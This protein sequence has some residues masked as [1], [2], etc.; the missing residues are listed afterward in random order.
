MAPIDRRC[1]PGSLENPL[2]RWLSPPS[3]DLDLLGVEESDVVADLGAGVGFYD[4]EILHRVGPHGR[5][6]AVDPDGDNLEVAHRRVKEDPRVVWL[7]ISAAQVDAIP[8]GSVDRVLLSLVICCLVDKEGVMDQTWRILKPGGVAF[9]SYL[10]RSIRP[11]SRR[12]SL[13]VLPSRWE[14]IERRRGWVVRPV[15]SSW[16]VARHLLQKPEASPR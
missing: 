9:V 8:E 15:P 16:L 2:R 6:F 12:Q 14:A 1:W 10:R 11:R 3:R 13:R 7:P 4:L 5:L